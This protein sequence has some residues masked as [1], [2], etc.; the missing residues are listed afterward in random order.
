MINSPIKARNKNA[1]WISR[2]SFLL[3]SIIAPVAALMLIM[4]LAWIYF[5]IFPKSDRSIVAV[6]GS[7][8]N[9]RAAPSSSADVIRR[10]S[11]YAEFESKNA[12]ADWIQIGTGDQ[13]CWANATYVVLD[14]DLKAGK[15][16]QPRLV[17]YL[18]QPTAQS[19]TSTRSSDPESL[20]NQPVTRSLTGT[21]GSDVNECSGSDTALAFQS[22]GE[23][24][25]YGLG[26]AR[27]VNDGSGVL[28]RWGRYEG[29]DMNEPH[30]AGQSQGVIKWLAPNRISIDWQPYGDQNWGTE[31]L[32]RCP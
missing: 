7:D 30:E 28:V 29:D 1:K 31:T 3:Y 4:I 6:I 23:F 22:N 5:H 12:E 10:V 20:K 2:N 25:G 13:A 27:W 11:G 26:N 15:G 17:E 24:W 16:Q 32:I 21:W 8:V 9:C 18:R 14:A 19:T